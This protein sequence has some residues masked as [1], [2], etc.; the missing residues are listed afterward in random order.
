MAFNIYLVAVD[1][2]WCSSGFSLLSE[3][4]GFPAAGLGEAQG[5]WGKAWCDKPGL[6]SGGF[7]SACRGGG[8]SGPAKSRTCGCVGRCSV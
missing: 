4:K 1:K 8:W 2:A 5:L 7:L 3:Q 6:M